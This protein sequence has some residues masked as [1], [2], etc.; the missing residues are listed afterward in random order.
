MLSRLRVS[1]EWQKR[2]RAICVLHTYICLTLANSH[3]CSITKV[4]VCRLWEGVC[5]CTVRVRA[6]LL[7]RSLS[8]FALLRPVCLAC[9]FIVSQTVLQVLQIWIQMHRHLCVIIKWNA[10]QCRTS[11]D[12]SAFCRT[13]RGYEQ[14]KLWLEAPAKDVAPQKFQ[15]THAT[16]FS[17]LLRLFFYH[18]NN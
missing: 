14:G 4:R 18:L 16:N 3:S 6:Q 17:I 1:P 8:R 5:M 15:K 9:G 12:A 13:L 2:F 7:D 10:I 11:R